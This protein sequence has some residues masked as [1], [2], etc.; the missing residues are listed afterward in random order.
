MIEKN[1]KYLYFPFK[2]V[3]KHKRGSRL[4]TRNQ[5]PG[6]IAYISSSAVN[7]GLDSY[8]S[9]PDY[10][11]LYNNKLT[12]SNSG[13]V[14][15][16]FYHDYDFV[17]SDHV[18]VIWLKDFKLNKYVAVFLK[19]V[20][21]KIRYRYNFGREISDDRLLFEQ[22]YLPVDENDLPDWQY[23]EDKMRELE[24][25]IKFKP[26]KAKKSQNLPINMTDWK[27]F[28]VDKLFE[29]KGTTTTPV[30]EL[31]KTYGYGTFPYITTRATNNGVS[32][33]YDFAT[34][35]NNVL[36]ADSAVSSFVSYQEEKFSASD[37][38]E[39]LKPKFKLNKYIALFIKTIFMKSAYKYAFGRK[40]SQDRI[41]NT[42]LL[43][44]VKNDKPD[45]TYMEN[46]IKSLP[47]ADCLKK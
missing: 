16:M 15:F 47:Y 35:P 33:F 44:P 21:E 26:I 34:E 4:I 13:S 22:I 17:A 43:L 5:I 7:N 14:G 24:K 19:T 6:D 45:F 41:K 10:M 36:A 18:M 23:M 27:E 2:Q 1:K 32:G 46:Y 8:I 9:P 3:F 25:Q 11:I 12:L 38:V 37:H 30:F 31:E 39:I 42:K 40:F 28:E 20:F 29:V